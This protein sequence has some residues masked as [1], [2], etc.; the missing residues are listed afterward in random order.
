VELT[1]LFGEGSWEHLQPL[2]GEHGALLVPIDRATIALVWS[3]RGYPAGGGYRDYHRLTTFHHNPWNNTGDAYDRDAALALARADAADFVARTRA[4]LERA[5]TQAPGPLPGGG[6]VVCALDTELLG[7][8]WYEGID[9][10][11]AVVEECARQDLELLRL[12]DA[13][14][15]LE[16]RPVPESLQRAWQARSWG[17]GG[18]LS[19]WSGPPVAELA[20]GARTAELEVLHAG[21]AA[22]TAAVRELLALQASDWAFLI[23]R[24]LAGSYARERFDGHR[25]AL[26]LALAGAGERELAPQLRNIAVDARP[27]ALLAG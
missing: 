10:L 21:A 14:E 6:L 24:G 8:W 19:T 17:H 7:H 3:E 20:F 2:A 22:P 25:R 1:S 5:R 15:L 16:P 12:D 18:D 9:W 13:L 27:T 26:G 23:T 4:R 11:V